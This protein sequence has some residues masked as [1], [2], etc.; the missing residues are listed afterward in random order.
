MKKL[1]V[2]V[3]ILIVCTTS[4]FAQKAECPLTVADIETVFGKGFKAED[5]SKIGDILSCKFSNKD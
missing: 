4:L 1:L 3:T 2:I 5:P